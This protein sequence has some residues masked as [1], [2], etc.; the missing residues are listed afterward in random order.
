MG[1]VPWE[2][3]PGETNAGEYRLWPLA[4]GDEDEPL[5]G[6]GEEVRTLS[7]SWRGLGPVERF[8]DWRF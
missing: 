8:K 6:P 5:L 4:D 3:D 1:V 2:D 7:T